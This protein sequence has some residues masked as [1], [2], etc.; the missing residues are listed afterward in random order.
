[1][2]IPPR[3]V[4]KGKKKAIPRYGEKEKNESDKGEM[5]PRRIETY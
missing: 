3:R 5:P 4:K 2:K 1:M